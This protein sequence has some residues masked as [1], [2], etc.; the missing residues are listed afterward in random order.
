MVEKIKVSESFY[1]LQMEGKYMGV[2]SVFLRVSD[3]ILNC[4]FCDSVESWKQGKDVGVEDI[5][6]DW[7]QKG[8]MEKLQKGAHLVLTGG[9]PVARQ[10]QLYNLLERLDN[11]FVEVETEGVILP[12]KIDKYI[13]HYTVSP[14]TSNSGM[15]F[16][17]RYD[18]TTLQWHVDDKKSYF[19]FVVDNEKDI[20][21]IMKDYVDKF[22]IQ[23][24]RVWLMP[25]A[26]T[27]DELIKKSS[28][29]VELC[30]QYNF[31]YSSR[32]HLIV[33]NKTTGV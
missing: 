5:I 10:K 9:S 20:N 22:K 7:E 17:D 15:S 25:Q 14:K 3:C 13:S 6:K 31:N 30:K 29:I 1:S 32:E 24:N 11:I 8:W 33:W 4:N 19:K 28:Y 23:N 27:R 16:K 2:L 21:E 12:F 26:S 18:I